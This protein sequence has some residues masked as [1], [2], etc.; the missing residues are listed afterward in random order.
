MALLNNCIAKFLK[1]SSRL[2]KLHKVLQHKHKRGLR[3]FLLQDAVLQSPRTLRL[4]ISSWFLPWHVVQV[5]VKPH[6][7]DSKATLCSTHPI[8][9]ESAIN[10]AADVKSISLQNQEQ[11]RTLCGRTGLMTQ[12]ATRW[13]ARQPP[14]RETHLIE[15]QEGKELGE[16]TFGSSDGTERELFRAFENI[17][18]LHKE[19]KLSFRPPLIFHHTVS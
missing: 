3:D 6:L 10:F 13:R 14:P 16:Q 9:S 15:F 5:T 12:M 7:A 8:T 18:V 1:S 4:T 11:M 2:C 17:C 19:S